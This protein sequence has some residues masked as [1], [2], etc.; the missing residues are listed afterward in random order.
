M[1]EADVTKAIVTQQVEAMEGCKMFEVGVRLDGETREEREMINCKWTK[2]ELYKGLGWLKF[3]NKEGR[4]IY[5]RPADDEHRFVLLDDLKKE[6][7]SQMAKDGVE[8]SIIVETSPGNF[9]AWLNLGKDV[10]GAV[11]SAIAK[12]LAKDYNCDMHSTDSKHYGRL[13]GFTNCKNKYKMENGLYPFVRLRKATIQVCAKS[14]DLID[15]AVNAIEAEGLREIALKKNTIEKLGEGG[16]G[17]DFNTIGYHKRTALEEFRSEMGGLRKR[18]DDLSW[19]DFV[20]ARNM[21]RRGWGKRDVAEAMLNGS[22][23][24]EERKGR[25]VEDYIERTINKIFDSPEITEVRAN[26]LKTHEF[27]Q[28][29]RDKVKNQNK[30]LER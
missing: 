10:S 8:P 19:C 25:Y 29:L 22:P 9:Q 5:I 11:R 12:K 23:N 14:R 4:H 15:E 17:D 13:A 1:A 7:I 28:K 3:K 24:I 18:S 26:L 16:V 20:A 21:V 6:T 30:E 2:G 27:M